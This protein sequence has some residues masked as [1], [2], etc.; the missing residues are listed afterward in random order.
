MKKKADYSNLLNLLDQFNLSPNLEYQTNYTH[1]Q[2]LTFIR[3][4]SNLQIIH[5]F[6]SKLSPEQIIKQIQHAAMA[7][8]HRVLSLLFAH[9]KIPKLP[10]KHFLLFLIKQ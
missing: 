4:E 10:L 3:Q 6:L 5:L 7:N 9:L 1:L 2:L 8:Q